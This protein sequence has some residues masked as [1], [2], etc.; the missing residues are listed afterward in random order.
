M[1]ADGGWIGK[2]R[3]ALKKPPGVVLKRIAKE[4]NSQAER[5][6]GPWRAARFDD[7][8]L[9]RKTGASSVGQLWRSL[10]ARPFPAYTAR[11]DPEL[12]DSIIPGESSRVYMSA[13]D[14]IGRKVN[15]LGSG[16]VD[17]GPE[18]DWLRDFKTG[19]RWP[20]A[21]IRSMDYMNP[22]RP[23]DV[24]VPWEL[25]RHQWLIPAGQA[26]LL[27]G[28]E[29]YANGVRLVLESWIRQNPYAQSVNWA[30]AMEAAMR[31]FSWS[32]LFHV[33]HESKAWS[34]EKF[35]SLFLRT[36]FLH[37]DFIARNLERAYVN[38]NHYVSNASGLVF[39]GLFFGEG[40][41]PRKWLDTG[42]SILEEEID[43]QVY[44]DGVD[45][46]ASVPYHR[47]VMELFMYPA[48][49]MNEHGMETPEPYRKKIENM[50]RYVI[51]YSRPDGSAPQ[52]GDADDARVLPLGGQ[53]LND[54]RYL[55]G[56]AGAAWGETELMECF[57]GPADEILWMMGPEAARAA[58]ERGSAGSAARS[59]AF[60]Q[61]GVYVMR[62]RNSHVF[63][64]CGPVGLAGYGG[65]G[66][67]DC[68]SFDAF[69]DGVALVVDS[70]SYVYTASYDWHNKFR[71]SMFHNT[72]VVD[73]E[74]I[75]RFVSPEQLWSLHDDARPDALD[76]RTGDI[77]IFKGSHSGYMRLP[78]PA[79]PVRTIALDKNRNR[80]AVLDVIEAGGEHHVTVPFNLAPGVSA[81][82]A[83]GER[84]LVLKT[85]GKEFMFVWADNARWNCEL[86]EGWFS[87]SYGVKQKIVRVELSSRG[88]IPPLTT[89]MA[90]HGADPEELL[91]WASGPGTA[92]K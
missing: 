39:A 31:V 66:H 35:Q 68:L 50:A 63:I 75:N 56:I 43:I 44:D 83:P 59:A 65:H 92:E 4:I 10:A 54:H 49:Y 11:L 34:D 58:L 84:G 52:Q 82:P 15:L 80:L 28:D 7:G 51:A 90:P 72:P 23:S 25:S 71:S 13:S 1:S 79:R 67:N 26:Y 57:S 53:D 18:I 61:G 48:L 19:F 74:E 60:A 70:G 86:K 2:A 73:G 41:A 47:L 91:A 32:W 6:L 85:G 46:E 45:Y 64:D 30:I 81:E 69:L 3:R 8:A 24:K 38:G 78:D 77:D 33:F 37:G 5:Y 20:G 21:D 36:L 76:W 22:D 55:A 27:S 9:L 12:V 87:P 40:R 17:I 14:A 16:L 42:K 62:G 89:V 29:K 88:P